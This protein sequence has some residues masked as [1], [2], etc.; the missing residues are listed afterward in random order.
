M[1]RVGSPEVTSW[2]NSTSGPLS[3]ASAISSRQMAR[4]WGS[5]SPITEA[6]NVSASGRR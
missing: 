5:R 6:L 3:A 1:T 2:T 4:I